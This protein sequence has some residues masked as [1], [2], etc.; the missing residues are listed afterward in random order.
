MLGPSP[1]EEGGSY[2]PHFP[3]EA[4][5]AGAGLNRASRPAGRS[6]LGLEPLAVPQGG[7]GRRA[8]R[9][10][11]PGAPAEEQEAPQVGKVSLR[12]SC[13]L[14]QVFFFFGVTA[15]VLGINAAIGRPQFGGLLKH[16][17]DWAKQKLW[18]LRWS[19]PDGYFSV[20]LIQ[21]AARREGTGFA[22][23]L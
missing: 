15:F 22:A 17:S 9:P 21:D 12:G 20:F 14:S 13:P 3:D 23:Q 10:G 16:V 8:P 19:P 11:V 1:R 2:S 4:P 6:G 7:R 18:R 5:E